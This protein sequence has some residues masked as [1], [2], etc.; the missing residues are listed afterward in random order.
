[1]Y[2]DL[3]TLYLITIGT[4]LASAGLT[5]WEHRTHPTRSHSLRL[6]AAGFA[7]LAVGCTSVL[8]RADLPA[9]LGPALSNLVILSGYLLVLNSVASLSGRR[10]RVRAFALLAVMA[11]I[12]LVAGAGGQDV[13]WKYVS[14]F[15]IALVSG[16]TAWELWRCDSLKAFKT[17][18]IAVAVAGIHALIYL[19]RAFILPW[20]VAAHGPSAQLLASNITMYEG[21]LYSVILPMTLIKLIREETLSR[22]VLES[23]TDYLTRLGNRRWFFEQ[24]ARAIDDSVARGPVAVLAFDLDQFKAIN[25][26]YGHQTG[27]H[28]LKA[29]AQIVRDVLGPNAILARIG[30]EEFA[31]LLSG[32]AAGQ[33]QALGEAAARRFADTIADPAGGLG[34]RATVSIGLARYD[35]AAPPLADALARADQALY[36]AK[37]LGGNRLEPAWMLEAAAAD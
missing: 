18:Y 6:L 9:V 12:W 11:L 16:L 4:L 24:G 10:Y 35:S 15:P 5:F 19:G 33:A 25:D 2:V 29:F 37:A 34:L 21:V 17:R 32:D 20:W 13:V 31:A 36:R 27:D 22:L 3:L 14:A 23:Q 26:R 1:M 28:V 7:T 8:F 30:G